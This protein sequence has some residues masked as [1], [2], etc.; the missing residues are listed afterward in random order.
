MIS[1]MPRENL[2][3][4]FVTRVD[5]DQPAQPQRLARRLKSGI[6]KEEVLY[7]PGSE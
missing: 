2:S 5:S 4:G 6:L 1:A 7:Y 3:S